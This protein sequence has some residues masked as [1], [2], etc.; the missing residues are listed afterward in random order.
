MCDVFSVFCQLT[1]LQL[2]NVNE[3][4]FACLDEKILLII[5]ASILIWN[6]I[7]GSIF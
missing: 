2:M 1:G 4:M 7:V 5:F 3:L 6:S